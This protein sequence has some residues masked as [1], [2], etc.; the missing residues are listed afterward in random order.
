MVNPGN[1]LT[2][3]AMTCHMT[4]EQAAAA[5]SK[6]NKGHPDLG[7]GGSATS[8]SGGSST[9]PSVKTGLTSFH[10]HTSDVWIFY[11]PRLGLGEPAERRSYSVLLQNGHAPR[12]TFAKVRAVSFHPP[13]PQWDSLKSWERCTAIRLTDKPSEVSLNFVQP[14][15]RPFH[16][17]SATSPSSSSSLS[18]HPSSP[19]F[20]A[21][22]QNKCA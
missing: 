15:P 8:L 9:V 1:H 12:L 10:W 3:P 20:L 18:V 13:P 14:S 22:L 2:P 21:L 19:S 4:Q 17:P 16:T 5:D 11:F 6:P 7:T